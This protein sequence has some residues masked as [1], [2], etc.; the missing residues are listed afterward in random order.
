MLTANTD[1]NHKINLKGNFAEKGFGFSC[2]KKAFELNLVGYLKYKS[3]KD[4]EIVVQ[5]DKNQIANFYSWCL[6]SSETSSIDISRPHKYNPLL[7][8]FSINNSI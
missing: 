5:G 3:T 8:Y 6:S 7:N 2:L 4:L 1:T